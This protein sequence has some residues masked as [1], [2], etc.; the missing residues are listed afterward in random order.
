MIE[1]V[2]VALLAVAVAVLHGAPF[3]TAIRT[4]IRGRSGF[5]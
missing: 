1:V 2:D 4:R 5:E 3:K